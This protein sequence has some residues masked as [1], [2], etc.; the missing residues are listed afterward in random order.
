MGPVGLKSRQLHLKA[1]KINKEFYMRV[2]KLLL[3]VSSVALVFYVALRYGPRKLL[4]A[5][6][7]LGNGFRRTF[8]IFEG[9]FAIE[10]LNF[11]AVE[12]D[13]KR[14]SVQEMQTALL[15]IF[16]IS[17]IIVGVNIG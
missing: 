14:T 6:M 12:Y 8:S 11:N 5:N 10:Q 13:G 3:L 16:N 9:E 2:A 7:W 17:N 1:Y 4:L 15:N